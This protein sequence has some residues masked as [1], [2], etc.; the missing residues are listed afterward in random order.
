MISLRARLF[1]LLLIA[2]GA[3]WL[4]AIAWVHFSTRDEVERALDA[5]LREAA[6]M[7]SSLVE[8]RRIDL[9]SAARMASASA[10]AG[11]EADAYSRQLSCQIWSLDGDL[12][13]RSEHAPASRLTEVASGFSES[14]VDGEVWRVYSIVNPEL[15]LRVMVGDNLSVRERLVGDVTTGLLL[16]SLLV[17]PA[18][19]GLIWLSVGH[20]LRPLN[21]IA[22]GLAARPASDLRPLPV[23]PAPREIRPIA[24]ALNDLLRRVGAAREHERSF[25]AY[26]AHELKTPLAGLRT[27]A[28]VARIAPDAETRRQ[29]L[30]R[31]EAGVVRTDRMV[32]Q[33]LALATVESDAPGEDERA[34]GLDAVVRQTIE[35]LRPAAKERGVSLVHDVAA[36]PPSITRGRFFLSMALRNLL[37]NAI[38]A[39]SPGQTV[40]LIAGPEGEGWRITVLDRGRGIPDAERERVRD[41]FYR[42]T[43]AAAGGSGLGLAIVG[44][45][46]ERLGG[47]LIHRPRPG[48]GEIAELRFA[49]SALRSPDVICPAEKF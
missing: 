28:Q 33:L 49:E 21:L 11:P 20:G 46:L 30:E 45:A 8:E 36:E 18:L 40:E 35:D 27:Q 48:G 42:A 3:V 19:A 1:L 17:L 25:I 15:G 4:S 14:L 31:L 44:A 26:A 47:S 29:A 9:A 34:T 24:T 13:G 38:E 7:V 43:N 37:E 22:A 23:V 39:S 5:R 2:T 41:R 10:P 12:V 32:R 16:P 6:Q